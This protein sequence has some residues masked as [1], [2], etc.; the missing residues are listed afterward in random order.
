MEKR[1]QASLIDY[2]KA[3]NK[4][5][6]LISDFFDD[7][8]MK[9]DL[10]R[11]ELLQ[12]VHKCRGDLISEFDEF[13]KQPNEQSELRERISQIRAKLDDLNHADNKK[14]YVDF[15]KKV[16]TLKKEIEK[17]EKIKVD[18]ITKCS[19]VSDLYLQE[20]FQKY[21]IIKI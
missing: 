16:R 13:E 20:C 17:E 4:P 15:K 18:L 12:R 1:L 11:E 21:L 3:V 2:E 14:L 6:L 19:Y 9:V 7:I 8:R 10:F 5:Q